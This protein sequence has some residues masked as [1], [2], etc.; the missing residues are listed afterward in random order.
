MK[1]NTV[2]TTIAYKL[3]VGL[4]G[5]LLCGFLVVHLAGNFLIYDT[6]GDYESYNHYAHALHANPLLPVAEMATTRVSA[7]AG[8][9]MTADPSSATASRPAARRRSATTCAA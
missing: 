5:L 8:V 1:S 2:T 4:S 3:I 7:P 6:G 9:P